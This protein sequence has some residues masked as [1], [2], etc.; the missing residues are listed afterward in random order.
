M[1]ISISKL[2]G[3]DMAQSEESEAIVHAVSELNDDIQ[4]R[5]M[6]GILRIESSTDIVIDAS[7]VSRLLGREWHPDDMNLS[8]VSFFGEVKEWDDDEIIIGW[9]H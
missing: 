3:I 9:S 6:P 5:R 2:T 7:V 4:V 8:I 1:V